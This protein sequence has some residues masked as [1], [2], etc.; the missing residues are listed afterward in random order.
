MRTFTV[1][2]AFTSKGCPTKFRKNTTY[3]GKSPSAAASKAFTELCRV[4]K[5][6]GV[7]TFYITMREKTQ[8]CSD[9]EFSY[10]LRRHKL[11]KPLVRF[12]GTK[13][14]FTIKYKNTIKSSAVPSKSTKCKGKSSGRMKKKSI[15]KGGIDLPVADEITKNGVAQKRERDYE[16]K[17]ESQLQVL[18]ELISRCKDDEKKMEANNGK[19]IL[20]E[21][22][23]RIS[24]IQ[25]YSQKN[26]KYKK[27]YKKVCN[28][29]NKLVSK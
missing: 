15:M 17:T 6:R 29:T 8:G 26:K 27:L 16:E 28:L 1:I 20:S 25:N 4:K 9:K 12:E 23:N 5:L 21:K 22:Q 10:L 14:E 7:A 24:A 18:D 19:E 2:G 11:D 13:K 3:T